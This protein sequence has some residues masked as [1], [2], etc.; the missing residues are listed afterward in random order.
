MLSSGVGGAAAK[1]ATR[2]CIRFTLACCLL[3]K[4]WEGSRQNFPFWVRSAFPHKVNKE[5]LPSTCNPVFQKLLRCG[6]SA[7][8]DLISSSVRR[9]YLFDDSDSS[10][11][12]EPFEHRIQYVVSLHYMLN[13]MSHF[14]SFYVADGTRLLDHCF[15][16]KSTKDRTFLK[17]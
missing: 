8:M 9:D 14:W 3:V 13:C 12:I 2:S 16:C 15:V 11:Q 7:I 4:F 5:L 10:I 1:H 17:G 6:T